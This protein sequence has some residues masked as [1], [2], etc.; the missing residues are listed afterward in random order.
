MKYESAIPGDAGT[1]G[2]SYGGMDMKRLGR[3][4]LCILLGVMCGCGYLPAQPRG[5]YGAG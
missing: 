4:G 2:V 3:L 1:G 5:R